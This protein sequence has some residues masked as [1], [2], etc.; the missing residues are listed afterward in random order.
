MKPTMRRSTRP[1]G[2]LR[3]RRRHRAGRPGPA[4]PRR[5]HP[6]DAAGPAACRGDGAP[7]RARCRTAG[8]RLPERPHHGRHHRRPATPTPA[9]FTGF[10]GL[11]VPGTVN[12]TGVPGIQLDGYFPDTSTFNT[13]HGWNHDAQFVIRLPR[14][15]NGGLVVA[16]P[17]GHPPPVRQRR[18]HLRLRAGQGLRLR[19]HRQGQ[20]RPDPLQGRS[21]AG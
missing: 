8:G 9:D 6:T 18:H 7:D 2:G 1:A 10:G 16:G 4:R 17:P 3:H 11:S 20:Q 15:W 21:E 14:H 5:R 13:T 12:P 19:L